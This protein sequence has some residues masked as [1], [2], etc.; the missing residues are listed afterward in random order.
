MGSKWEKSDDKGLGR[1]A[2]FDV[3][4]LSHAVD[5]EKQVLSTSDFEQVWQ[6]KTFHKYTI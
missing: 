2:M 6:R 1:V 3:V 4:G 5:A